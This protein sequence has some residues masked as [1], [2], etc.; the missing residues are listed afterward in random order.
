M[1]QE[2]G[3]LG[4][5]LES[6][7]SRDGAARSD[8]ILPK[9]VGRIPGMINKDDVS[10][11]IHVQ[12]T[13]IDRLET[14]N[15]SIVNCNTMAQ[16][17]LASTSR[18]FKK[19]AKA[20]SDSKKDLDIIYKKILDMKAKIRA[21]RPD[22]FQSEEDDQDDQEE[23]IDNTRGRQNEVSTQDSIKT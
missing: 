17:K 16:T 5:T 2:P 13:A 7:T 11:M 21:E 23:V 12:L 20:L 9:I 4:E 18:L 1:A 14:T 6:P 15:K 22:L 3:Q 10:T 19:T 8:E